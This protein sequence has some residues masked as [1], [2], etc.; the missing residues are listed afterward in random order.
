MP[1]NRNRKPQ[2]ES[3]TLEELQ[4]RA[5]GNKPTRKQSSHHESNLQ[6]QCVNWFRRQ[7]PAY[8]QVLF[9]VPNGGFRQKITAKIL[10]AEGALSGVADLILL[11]SRK[12]YTSLCIEMKFGK[13]TQS[14]SQK[15]WQVEA[16]KNGSRYVV[17]R[18]F[19]EFYQE[20]TEYLN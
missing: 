9:A 18:S 14:E 8:S 2:R 7:Y 1:I 5:N 6:I 10:K 17:V 13:G 16:E 15:A 19:E 4:K 12:G 3:F 11:L 20:V